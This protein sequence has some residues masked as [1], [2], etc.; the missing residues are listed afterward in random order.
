MSKKRSHKV[1]EDASKGYW[2]GAGE[3]EGDEGFGGKGTHRLEKSLL[4]APPPNS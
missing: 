4:E 3:K 1:K 2:D